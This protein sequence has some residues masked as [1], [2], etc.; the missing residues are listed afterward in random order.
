MISFPHEFQLD[1]KDCGPACIKIIAKYY[2]RFFTLHYLRDL[3]GI[4]KEG[5]SFLDM[6]IAFENI[7]LKTKCIDIGF[8]DLLRMPLPCVIH[9]Q[10]SHFIV[11]YKINNKKAYVS[12]PAK[13]LLSY[14]I[15][16]FK[17]SWLRGRKTWTVMAIQPSADFKQRSTGDRSER[18]RTIEN[19]ISYFTPYKRNFYHL[20]IL[21]FIVTALQALLPFISKAIIDVGIQTNDLSFVDLVLIGNVAIIVSVMLSNLTRDWILMHITSRVN[22]SLVSDYLIKLMKLPITFFENK[23][24]GDILQRASDHEQIRSFLMNSSINFIFS[25]LT[26]LVFGTILCYYDPLLCLIYVIGSTLFVLWVVVFSNFRKKLDWQYFD[27]NAENQSYWVETIT[28]IQD[29]KINNYERQKR[30]KWEGIQAKMYRVNQKML[31]IGNTQNLGAQFINQLTNLS[32]T[33][34]CARAVIGGGLSFGMMIST[35]FIIGMLNGPIMQFVSFIQSAQAAKISFLRLNEIHQLEEEEDHVVNS[36]V[37]LPDTK[38]IFLRNVGFQY[39]R[40]SMPVLRNISIVIPEGLTTAIVGD[41]GSGKTTLLKLILRLYKPSFGEITIGNMNIENINLHQWRSKCGAVMQ[42]GKIFNDTI[43]NNIVLEDENIDYKKLKES[44][45]AANIM[46]EI[47]ALPLGYQTFM[48]EQ[49]RGLSGGQKQRILIAR[50]LYKDPQYL[51]LDEATNSL[52]TVNEQKIIQSF[53]EIFKNKTVIVVAHRLSTIKRAHQ[54][55]V[56][57]KGMV[58]EVGN[59]DMLSKN[60]SGHYAQLVKAQME[61]ANELIG[62]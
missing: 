34:Y 58:V 16:S 24:I 55:I 19:F 59:H 30:W 41:S 57:S 56:M 61:G 10:E 46:D 25:V 2:G 23:M 28:S 26:F 42:E 52:D 60:V 1:S 21:M 17:S 54:I 5:I 48:G 3:C 45:K 47:E 50:A 36:Q 7:G 18:K 44:V 32:I 39:S 62:T 9:W 15:N 51:F 6:S 27:L 38:N 31:S 12:D 35:Q 37:V 22:I 8:E 13:G 20:F 43:L 4:S 40:N 49:G 53:D 29:I 33:F 11:L 14:D